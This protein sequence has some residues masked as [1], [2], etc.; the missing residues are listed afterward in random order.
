MNV[1]LKQNPLTRLSFSGQ[2]AGIV[3]SIIGMLVFL[4]LPVW[5]LLSRSV[6][7]KDGE[8]IGLANFA[9]YFQTP[10][11][12]E[13]AWNSLIIAAACTLLV[14]SSAFLYAYAL[15]RTSM[16]GKSVFRLLAQ[17]PMLAPSMMPAIGL[18]YLF[19][20]QGVIK[21]WFPADSVYGAGGIIVGLSL[22]CFPHALIIINTA[23]SLSDKRLHEAA[24]VM[25]TPAW[26]RFLTVTL[27]A[28]R[29]GL[30]SAALVV[31]TLVLADF[32]VPKV[33]GGQFDVL[34]T[35]IYKRVVGQQNF[36][37][38]AVVGVLLLLPSL[39]A[40]GLDRFFQR[41]QQESFSTSAVPYKPEANT[42]KDT[43]ALIYCSVVAIGLM[44]VIGMA[45]YASFVTFWPYNLSFTL[46]N[47]DFD[48][49]DG[50]GW[51]AWFNS[52]EMAFLTALIGSLCIFL[53]AWLNEKTKGLKQSRNLLHLLAFM[54][55]AVPGL[56]LGLG[57]IFFFNHPDNPL[58]W[59]YGTMTIL[60]LSTIAHYF[61][62]PYLTATT[63]LKQIPNEFSAVAD[64]LKVSQAQLF[65]RVT[66]PLSLPALLDISVY[67]FLAAI[68]TVSAVVFLYSTDTT[69]AAVAILNM[70]EAG[71]TSPAAAMA[72]VVFVSA[73]VVRL[74]HSGLTAS[75][76]KHS[77]AWQ[78]K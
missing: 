78:L 47:Y 57:Y 74:I 46:A 20:N 64:S 9:Y 38:G 17:L 23:L 44:T 4:V 37:M 62:V 15:N 19:G 40:F 32:G 48:M 53:V 6:E 3:L 26:R 31:F 12:L 50:G 55:L 16:P 66:L 43:L 63:A 45:I 29:Y 30:I 10:A 36:Q 28:A 13:S 72:T 75:L 51:D 42:T 56:V 49:M 22:W 77:Q 27:P 8:F 7:N 59:I 76:R 68:T 1:L 73:T 60:V 35:D 39:L 14:T 18:I 5:S 25:G 24:R 54:P 58:H 70:D 71:D 33:I 11:L 2:G 67:L 34:A 21:E 69:L 65:R 41:K 52:I 61:T